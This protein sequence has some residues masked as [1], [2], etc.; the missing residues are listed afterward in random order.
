MWTPLVRKSDIHLGAV[1][2]MLYTLERL[3]YPVSDNGNGIGDDE[4]TIEC[5]D[6]IVSHIARSAPFS[7]PDI[8]W[9]Y[10][11]S[12][13]WRSFLLNLCTGRNRKP[14]MGC[15]HMHLTDTYPDGIAQPWIRCSNIEIGNG[16]EGDMLTR[17]RCRKRDSPTSQL[18]NHTLCNHHARNFLQNC[19][20]YAILL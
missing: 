5:V 2:L 15:I 19:H 3:G 4:V 13:E 20:L 16:I 14:G 12:I 7:S 8:N 10:P 1:I 11:V 17:S 6:V 18:F 9:L